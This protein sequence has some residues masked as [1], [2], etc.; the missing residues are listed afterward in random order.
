MAPKTPQICVIESE[1]SRTT[2]T[3]SN[4]PLAE[5]QQ[6]RSD[7]LVHRKA[8]IA[9]TDNL[10]QEAHLKIERKTRLSYIRK[11]HAIGCEYFHIDVE[12]GQLTI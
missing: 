1:S 7:Q 3:S 9:A 5:T 8:A 11:P 4:L 2:G 12:H 10:A 6:Q